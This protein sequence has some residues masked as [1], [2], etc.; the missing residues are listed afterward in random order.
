GDMLFAYTAC[1]RELI[2]R[3]VL[4]PSQM[5]GYALCVPK[6]SSN[7][8]VSGLV[9]EMPYVVTQDLDDGINEQKEKYA[10]TDLASHIFH[11]EADL[12]KAMELMFAI[13][14]PRHRALVPHLQDSS[15]SGINLLLQE[16]I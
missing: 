8:V 1:I 4:K 3:D 11:P 2:V 14:G 9:L 10:F 7:K 12:G 13:L 16:E 15:P 5:D 6:Q